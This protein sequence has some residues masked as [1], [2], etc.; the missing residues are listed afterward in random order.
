MIS[1]KDINYVTE[2]ITRRFEIELPLQ[3]ENFDIKDENLYICFQKREV[4]RT[5][6]LSKGVTI[7]FDND[8]RIIGLKLANIHDYLPKS[9]NVSN[10]V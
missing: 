10:E 2:K 9:S 5:F 8:S 1:E 7:E 3:F 6:E 4:N